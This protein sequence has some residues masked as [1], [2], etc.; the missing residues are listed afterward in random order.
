VCV[1]LAMM[2]P[3]DGCVLQWKSEEPE[4]LACETRRSRAEGKSSEP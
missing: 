1:K 2:R 3:A 4:I